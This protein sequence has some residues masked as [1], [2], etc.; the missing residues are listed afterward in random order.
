MIKLP[1]IPKKTTL[2]PRNGVDRQIVAVDLF[3][4]AGGLTKGLE[5]AGIRV[6][7][8]IDVDP[9]CAYPYTVNNRASFVQKS[10]EDIH[11]K[12][13]I[14]AYGRSEFTLLAGCAPCQPFSTYR[15]GKSDESDGRWNLLKE[16]QR[17]ALEVEPTLVTMENVRHPKAS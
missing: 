5:K 8:G 7:L 4:G 17:L 9:A 14:Y 1:K 2:L 10:V 12:E 11:R 16:F 3:C 6:A 15:I 13:L